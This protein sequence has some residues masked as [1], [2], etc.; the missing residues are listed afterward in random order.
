MN[1]A[2]IVVPTIALNAGGVAAYLASGWDSKPAASETVAPGDRQWQYWPAPATN[3][4]FIRG[5]ICLDATA[6][7]AGSIARALVAAGEPMTKQ[8]RPEGRTI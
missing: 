1:I 6:R 7:S 5:N 4:A 3:N 8:K 2:S